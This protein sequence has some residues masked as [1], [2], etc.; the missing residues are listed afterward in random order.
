MVFLLEKFVQINEE[1]DR[2]CRDNY[3]D[4]VPA[5]R[6]EFDTY[7]S[8]YDENVLLISSSSE[9]S[10]LT[11]L[12]S[13]SETIEGYFLN[14]E[15]SSEPSNGLTQMQLRLM[16]QIC[17]EIE[18]VQSAV[19]LKT[20]EKFW[21]F[22]LNKL[23]LLNLL[24]RL[25]SMDDADAKNQFDL[26]ENLKKFLFCL[27]L[28]TNNSAAAIELSIFVYDEAMRTWDAL[29][30]LI[31]SKRR[32][33]DVFE[34]DMNGVEDAHCCSFDLKEFEHIARF[35]FYQIAEKQGECECLICGRLI[36][37]NHIVNKPGCLTNRF[38]FLIENP[39]TQSYKC[40]LNNLN[41][42][43][44][45]THEPFTEARDTAD[46]CGTEVDTMSFACLAF[47][48][49]TMGAF[50]LSSSF[51]D[52]SLQFLHELKQFQ[53]EFSRTF[54]SDERQTNNDD[55]N[56]Y[57][58]V[59]FKQDFIEFSN[60]LAS[61]ESVKWDNCE[62]KSESNNPASSSK[63]NTDNTILDDIVNR[64]VKDQSASNNWFSFDFLSNQQENAAENSNLRSCWT[65]APKL[66]SYEGLSIN[67]DTNNRSSRVYND[68]KNKNN[69]SKS[70]LKPI[71]AKP[72][73]MSCQFNRFNSNRSQE[74]AHTS[75]HNKQTMLQQAL[76][77]N[78]SCGSKS[79]WNHD[80]S[81]DAAFQFSSFSFISPFIYYDRMSPSTSLTMT[82]QM[83]GS[84]YNS[85]SSLANSNDAASKC[86]KYSVAPLSLTSNKKASL[87][88]NAIK[89]HFYNSNQSYSQQTSTE[90]HRHVN[91]GNYSSSLAKPRYYS[92]NEDEVSPLTNNRTFVNKSQCKPPPKNKFSLNN[93]NLKRVNYATVEET[94]YGR[95]SGEN[96][97]L[98][99]AKRSKTLGKNNSYNGAKLTKTVYNSDI[100]TNNSSSFRQP[101]NAA[102]T[103]K[104]IYH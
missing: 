14:Q 23:N 34:L 69:W 73:S 38:D 28:F 89:T 53:W 7:E 9:S 58:D 22:L 48:Y 74:S 6:I 35:I 32:A 94:N 60:K 85:K 68:V 3:F 103:D 11:S 95:P 8:T 63:I 37:V 39:I 77:N 33:D 81:E 76:F 13:S 55:T 98:F 104:R 17:S 79:I 30:L 19:D 5:A 72:S 54:H 27:S 15:P 45:H 51:F 67:E 90:Y 41:A 24:A 91:A 92:Y 82:K 57:K 99:E 61:V 50:E 44:Y 20:N 71:G 43:S 12:S 52:N 102:R 87:Q 25:D 83:S 65:V 10:G 70:D 101:F 29:N 88:S 100:Y 36:D 49:Y 86:G 1:F 16:T 62:S 80:K 84:K 78:V 46:E 4:H 59:E 2:R 18:S 93:Q 64:L 75:F 26:L 31:I 40:L 21:Q 42:L 97:D 47:S 96:L 66:F 56:Y